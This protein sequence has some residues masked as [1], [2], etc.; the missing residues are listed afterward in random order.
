MVSQLLTLLNLANTPHP[1]C[2]S[3]YE[4]R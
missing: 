2:L 3:F 4:R 1:R